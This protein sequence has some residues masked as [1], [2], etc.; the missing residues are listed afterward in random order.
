MSRQK[1][2]A[3]AAPLDSVFHDKVSCILDLRFVQMQTHAYIIAFLI[4]DSLNV[5]CGRLLMSALKYPKR[6]PSWI[7]KTKL[8]TQASPMAGSIDQH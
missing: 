4:I 2:I 6:P 5:R 3:L 7:A 1:A 8:E